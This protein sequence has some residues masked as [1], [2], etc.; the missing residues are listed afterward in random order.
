MEFESKPMTNYE[1]MR[2]LLQFLD[3]QDF[4]RTHW[5]NSIGWGMA[6]CMNELVVKKN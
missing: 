2:N 3:V 5:S 1:N 4:S 6:N